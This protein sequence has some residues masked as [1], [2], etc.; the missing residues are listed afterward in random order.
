M[1]NLYAMRRANGDWFTLEDDGRLLIPVFHSSHDAIISR[2]RT[3]EM[4][5]FSPMALTAQLLSEIVDKPTAVHFCLIS[6]P[7]ASLKRGV[8]LSPAELLSF[9]NTE[10]PTTMEMISASSAE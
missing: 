3:V 5:V 9:I 10:A 1:T 2:L 8:P 6:N 7:F 4:L